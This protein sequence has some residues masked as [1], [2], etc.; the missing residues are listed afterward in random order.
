MKKLLLSLFAISSMM[1]ANAQYYYVVNHGGN[2]KGLNTDFEYSTGN[3]SWPAGWN[4]IYSTVGA[5]PAWSATQNIGFAFMFNGTPVTSFKVS[6]SGVLTFDATTTLAAPSVAHTNLPSAL[7]PKKSICAWGLQTVARTSFFAQYQTND[8]VTKTFGTAGNRQLWIQFNQYGEPNLQLGWTYWSIVLEEGT[9][10]IY[11]VDQ[12]TQGVNSSGSSITAKTSLT[13]GIQTD[14]VTAYQV[15]G[16]PNVANLAGASALT[17]DNYF[18]EFNT[19]TQPTINMRI[20][21]SQTPKTTPNTGTV[22]IAVN[23]AN[24]GTAAISTATF[25][26][27]INGGPTVTSTNITPIS[28]S[29]PNVNVVKETHATAFVPA[30][31]DVGVLKTVAV[32]FTAINGGAATSDTLTLNFVINKGITGNKHVLIEEGSGAW[33]GYCVDGHI[34]LRDILAQNPNVVGVVHHNADGMVNANS[35]IINSLYAT[36]YPYGTVDKYLFSGQTTVGLNRGQWASMAASRLNAPTPVNV[37]IA[38]KTFNATTRTVDFDVKA[39]FVDYY[40]GDLRVN[41]YI[42]EDYVRGPLVSATST[43][44]NQHNYYSKYF[45]TPQGGTTHELYNQPEYFYGYRH[46]HVVRNIL[47]TPFG[48]SGVI[49]P[50]S[51]LNDSKTK[52][53]SYTL[54]AI[55]NVSD[56]D[57]PGYTNIDSSIYQSTKAGPAQN[58]HYDSKIVAFISIY[59]PDPT[60]VEILN[61]IEVPLSFATGVADVKTSAVIGAKIY[62]NPTSGITQVDFNLTST[63]N[64]T[65][66]VIDLVGKKI[67]D[68]KQGAFANGTH[69]VYFDATDLNNGVYFV[70]I[71]SSEGSATQKFVV[72]K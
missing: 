12:E 49:S 54:P 39:D 65:V 2:P 45:S 52:H 6:S 51:A 36:G 1:V 70:N 14:S 15:T 67:M 35:D 43:T 27:S 20:L 28:G 47:T 13:V 57:F 62:P 66:E 60:K 3:T 24:L 18:Y 38:N 16:S 31:S 61:V 22:S 71:K 41:V 17:G 56:A 40:Y 9:N 59:N 10:K 46:N 50:L 21:G 68:V 30:L 23:A 25:N 64:V 5:A 44:W 42:V 7:I 48:E 72:S 19:G 33:C 8:I 32:W 63:S 26:Y 53:Y 55:V 37:S 4:K 11:I 34:I 29:V 69:S 58:K